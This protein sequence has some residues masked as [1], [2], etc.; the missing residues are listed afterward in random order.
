MTSSCVSDYKRVEQSDLPGEYDYRCRMSMSGGGCTLSV[1]DQREAEDI[2]D[3]DPD[4]KGF[5]MTQQHTWTGTSLPRLHRANLT[6]TMVN[7]R[8]KACVDQRI[9]LHKCYRL[10][11]FW[12]NYEHLSRDYSSSSYCFFYFL[13]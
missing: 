11:L 12:F 2:C 6:L 13:L 8:C 4:C 10:L 5:V 7:V 9:A 1:F 3:V